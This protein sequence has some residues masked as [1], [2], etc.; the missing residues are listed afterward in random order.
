[1][2]SSMALLA[3]RLRPISYWSCLVQKRHVGRS[4]HLRRPVR[5][6]VV[7][8]SVAAWLAVGRQVWLC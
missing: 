4:V 5:N 3:V 2:L 7:L 8:V 1:M 6:S